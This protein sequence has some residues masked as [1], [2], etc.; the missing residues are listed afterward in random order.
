MLLTLLDGKFCETLNCDSNV[1]LVE[2][3]IQKHLLR[4]LFKN[5]WN[6]YEENIISKCLKGKT[7]AD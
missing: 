6:C 7:C 5:A 4:I 2:T 3:D 1:G